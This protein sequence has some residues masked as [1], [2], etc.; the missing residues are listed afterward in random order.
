MGSVSSSAS[1]VIWG[2][3][4]MLMVV[5]AGPQANARQPERRVWAS[6]N[7]CKGGG[8]VKETSWAGRKPACSPGETFGVSLV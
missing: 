6:A 1:T 3:V 5:R 7:S 4:R 8:G 2:E